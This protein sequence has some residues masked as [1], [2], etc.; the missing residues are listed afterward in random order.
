[1]QSFRT[2]VRFTIAMFAVPAVVMALV[3]ALLPMWLGPS[4]ARRDL[5]MYSGIAAIGSVQFVVAAYIV[6]AFNEPE[7]D[8]AS[9]AASKK[10]S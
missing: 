9:E 8:A 4:V 10:R 1:M 2:L 7:P 5:V 3:Y 6:Y